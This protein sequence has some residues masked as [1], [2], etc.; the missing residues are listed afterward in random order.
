MEGGTNYTNQ[1]TVHDE[2]EKAIKFLFTDQVTYS[3]SMHYN[4]V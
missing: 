2:M 1:I 3:I 4:P